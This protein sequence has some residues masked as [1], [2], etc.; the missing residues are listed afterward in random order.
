MSVGAVIICLGTAVGALLAYILVE[1]TAPAKT[2]AYV[3]CMDYRG[4]YMGD[5]TEITPPT[6]EAPWWTF[7]DAQTG[8]TVTFSG[9]CVITPNKP[10]KR[11]R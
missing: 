11:K 4:S 8:R 9:R 7:R 6:A 1:G 10:A 5:V 2:A 3:E